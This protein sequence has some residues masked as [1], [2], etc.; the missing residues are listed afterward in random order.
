MELIQSGLQEGCWAE[1]MECYC[2]FRNV[3]DLSAD[4]QTPCELRFISKQCHHLKLI[5]TQKI[6]T[7]VCSLAGRAKSRKR[8]SR[9]PPLC[10]KRGA[11]SGEN[12]KNILQNVKEEAPDPSPDVEARPDFCR[13][14]VGYIYCSNNE[15]LFSCELH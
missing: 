1:A 5:F 10:T 4:G 6:T 7:N 11:T 13:N 14:M 15:T 12:R 2:S 9:Y 8:D 3:T